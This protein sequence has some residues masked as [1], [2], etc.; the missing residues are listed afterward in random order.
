MIKPYAIDILNK[1]KQGGEFMEY[2]ALIVLAVVMFGGCFALNDVYQKMCGNSIKISMQFSALSSFAGL[3]VLLIINNFKFEFTIFTLI[4]AIASSVVSVGFTFCSFKALGSINL[5]LYSLFSMLGGMVLP[6][7][8]GIVFHNEGMTLSKGV[9]MILI[10][11]ALA[12]TVERGEKNKG[13]IYYAG[14]FVLNGMVGVISTL[15]TK[16]DYPKTSSAG[17]SV[18]I[19]ICTVLLSLIISILLYGK[20]A[21]QII[22]PSSVGIGAAAGIINRVANY[23]LLISLVHIDSSVQY[24][25]ITGGVMIVS[26]IISLFGNNKP[27]KKEIIS[28]GLAFLGMFALFAIPI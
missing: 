24:P 12:L 8:Q 25:L 10:I 17:F 16:S 4:M 19:A 20:T 9:C 26:T 23:L 21:F 7:V 11:A 18:L 15:F 14:V 2:Y 5:S 27:S 3:V 13:Y 6:F 1:V 22:T 28:V